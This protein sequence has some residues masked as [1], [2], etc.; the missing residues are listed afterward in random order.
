MASSTDRSK[1]RRVPAETAAAFSAQ[2]A[3]AK[4][5]GAT[6]TRKPHWVYLG[7]ATDTAAV[8]ERQANAAQALAEGHAAS[9]AGMMAK[10][11]H[12]KTRQV[13]H[14]VD[15][16]LRQMDKDARAL[17]ARHMTEKL[18]LADAHQAE[19]VQL[20]QRKGSGEIVTT[21]VTCWRVLE[22]TRCSVAGMAV[23]LLAL[24]NVAG[25]RK[26]LRADE[27]ERHGTFTV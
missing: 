8:L 12:E 20:L 2:Q 19:Q 18:D 10:Q 21:G 3:A 16:F 9:L 13:Q 4:Q 26:I 1:R 5:L 11:Q 24:E 6:A 15:H 27:I 23:E 14:V 25:E 22:S 17:R 7:C